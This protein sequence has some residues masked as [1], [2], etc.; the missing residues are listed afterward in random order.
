LPHPHD[1]ARTRFVTFDEGHPLRVGAVGPDQ[2][3]GPT[4]LPLPTTFLHPSVIDNTHRYAS[5]CV[6]RYRTTR[7]GVKAQCPASYESRRM[8]PTLPVPWNL[9][10]GGGTGQ[11]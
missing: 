1:R 5:Q 6:P 11:T 2:H 10:G 4:C 9:N 3:S 8:A 7:C